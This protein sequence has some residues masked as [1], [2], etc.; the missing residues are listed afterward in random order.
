MGVDGR[1][2][3]EGRDG[4]EGREVVR[5]VPWKREEREAV[6]GAAAKAGDV[7]AM[8]GM[9]GVRRVELMECGRKVE[10]VKKMGLDADIF[11]WVFVDA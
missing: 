1:R 4:R 5:E 11:I 3:V 8:M 7:D 6:S 10:E 9:L 2:E